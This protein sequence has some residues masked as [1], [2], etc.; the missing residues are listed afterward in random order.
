[1][2]SS[3]KNRI[4]EFFSPKGKIWFLSPALIGRGEEQVI[5]D[6]ERYADKVFEA[7][8]Q[9]ESLIIAYASSDMNMMQ[10]A[11]EEIDECWQEAEEIRWSVY[12]RIVERKLFF[13]TSRSDMLSL[14]SSMSQVLQVAKTI[15]PIK[16]PRGTLSNEIQFPLKRMADLCVELAQLMASS[17][18]HLNRD[19][20]YALKETRRSTDYEKEIF[21]WKAEIIRALRK[22]RPR[23]IAFNLLNLIEGV[24][25]ITR[26]IL[27]AIYKV[28]ET[29]VKFA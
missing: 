5:L 6:L 4:V 8:D 17:V 13:P 20:L 14:L 9:L 25:T 7:V 24:S 1:M 16:V 29:A 11:I 18:E 19:P 2:P 27:S 21:Y 22:E 3:L 10:L 12:T 15:H 23:S 28:Q 26:E